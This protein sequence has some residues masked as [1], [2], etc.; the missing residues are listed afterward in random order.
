MTKDPYDE[1]G[2]EEP[3]RPTGPPTIEGQIRNF[4]LSLG[5][6]GVDCR[7]T[8]NALSKLEGDERRRKLLELAEKME[9]CAAIVG[10]AAGVL[11]AIAQL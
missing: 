3:T 7:E 5:E 8:A 1:L 9:E 11:R 2:S 10:D 4:T 6:L